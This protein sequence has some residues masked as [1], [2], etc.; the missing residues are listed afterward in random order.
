MNNIAK[1][2]GGSGR[3]AV[4][5]PKGVIAVVED[6]VLAANVPGPGSYDLPVTD[7]CVQG[8]KQIVE[9]CELCL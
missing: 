4:E 1:I 6:G 5:S 8:E 2:S 7:L 9:V 3:Y